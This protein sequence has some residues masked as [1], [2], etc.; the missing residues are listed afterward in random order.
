MSLANTSAV[1]IQALV[2]RWFVRKYTMDTRKRSYL[3][4]KREQRHLAKR[5]RCATRIQAVARAWLVRR[6]VPILQFKVTCMH[7]KRIGLYKDRLHAYDNGW[8]FAEEAPFCV[9]HQQECFDYLMR[10]QEIPVQEEKTIQEEKPTRKRK[11][12]MPE[13]FAKRY[14][15]SR[16]TGLPHY[17]HNYKVRKVGREWDGNYP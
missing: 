1:R 7:C 14:R 10:L 12:N 16:I 6:P 5:V 11:I 9:E 8:D 3:R 13:L 15:L 17:I 2:R 4:Y